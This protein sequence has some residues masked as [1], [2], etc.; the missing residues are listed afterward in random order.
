[1]VADQ[2]SAYV[3][4]LDGAVITRPSRFC[5]AVPKIPVLASSAQHGDGLMIG[6]RLQFDFVQ[7]PRGIETAVVA[8]QFS[9]PAGN[10][11]PSAYRCRAGLIL[12]A[13][14]A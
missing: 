3:R 13:A 6:V 4:K 5:L 10:I 11:C 9:V 1:V 12:A 14:S 2:R 8:F 7:F